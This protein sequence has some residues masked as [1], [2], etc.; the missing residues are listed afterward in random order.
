MPDINCPKCKKSIFPDMKNCPSCGTDI[1]NLFKPYELAKRK[2]IRIGWV[3]LTIALVLFVRW[4]YYQELKPDTSPRTLREATEDLQ[5]FNQQIMV[6]A[7][8]R[9]KTRR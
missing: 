2:N 8:E 3:I 6:D 9:D 1:S 4:L 7:I 5:K